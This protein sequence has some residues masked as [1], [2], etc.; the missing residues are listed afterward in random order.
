MKRLLLFAFLLLNAPVAHAQAA[1]AVLDPQIAQALIDLSFELKHS[2]WRKVKRQLVRSELPVMLYWPNASALWTVWMRA[3]VYRQREGVPDSVPW[4]RFQGRVLPGFYTIERNTEHIGRWM[5]RVVR[6]HQ[7]DDY[8]RFVKL[9]RRQWPSVGEARNLRVFADSTGIVRDVQP[10][11]RDPRLPL[12][13]REWLP[14]Q[15]DTAVLTLLSQQQFRVRGQFRTGESSLHNHTST[16]GKV[17]RFPVYTLGKLAL[18]L[19]RGIKRGYR[20]LRQDLRESPK[21]RKYHRQ[22]RK[23]RRHSPH[24]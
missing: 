1:P 6:R 15:T 21:A 18:D 11:W 10:I 13:Q 20:Q 14:P 22:E 5:N 16:A 4:P 8:H 7:R 23:R 12:R 19:K 24:Y 9:L 2:R 17:L 3:A